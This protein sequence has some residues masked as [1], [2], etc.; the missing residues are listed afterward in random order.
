[1]LFH[2]SNGWLS[3]FEH[4]SLYIKKKIKSQNQI[5]LQTTRVREQLWLEPHS[6]REHTPC[7]Y[8]TLSPQGHSGCP[9]FVPRSISSP[10]PA[11]AS[12]STQGAPALGSQG[13]IFTVKA[14]RAGNQALAEG[15][16]QQRFLSVLSR[17]LI[18]TLG[19][20]NK[21]TTHLGSASITP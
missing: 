7:H 11:P 14:A 15:L 20:Q 18:E 21:N 2:T 12:T 13:R 8:S 10:A 6:R 4:L 1:M 16:T 5:L 17:A 3:D 19:G 9:P